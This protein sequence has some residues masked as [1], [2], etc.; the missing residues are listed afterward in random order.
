VKLY[1]WDDVPLETISERFARKIVWGERAM[2]AQIIMK[3]GCLV[4]MHNHE[5]EQMTQ[6]FTG[7]LKFVIAGQEIIVRP[8]EILRIPSWVEH[9]AEAL[10]DTMEVDTFSPIRH[11]WIDKTDDY[12]RR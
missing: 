7:A 10:E 9:S 11:D 2:V 8:G 12:L 1:N 4:P 6:V 3:K 5:S